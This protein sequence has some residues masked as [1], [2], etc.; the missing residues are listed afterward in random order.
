MP[1]LLFLVNEPNWFVSHRLAV[2]RAA[3][4][5]GFE[6]HVAGP[7]Q[8]PKEILEAGMTFHSV[9]LCRKGMNPFTELNAISS[10]VSLFRSVRPDI[11][12]LVTIKPYLYGGIA[13]RIVNIPAV[14]S[15]VAGLGTAFIRNDLLARIFRGLLYP[16]FKLAFGHGRQR[17]IFQNNDDRAVLEQ[18]GV[19][20]A[21]QS[22]VI[23]GSGADL[24]QYRPCAEIEGPPIIA[25]AARLLKDKGLVEFIDAARILKR[26]GIDARFWVIGER[27]PGNHATATEQEL[28]FWRT[29]GI[30]QFLGYRR[31][32]PDLF[33]Q[34]HI[35]CLPS[36]REGLPKVLVEG[37][38]A[39]RAVVTTNV[40]GCRDAIEPDRTGL[41]VPVRDTEKLADALQ[42]LIQNPDERR[43]MG[44]AGRDLAEREFEIGKIV[45][46]HLDIYHEL[47]QVRRAEKAEQ[48]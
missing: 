6:V 14:V 24:I 18:W 1:R 33:R 19:V 23:R 45:G 35:I 10:L 7:G 30:V 46:A 17:V 2:G 13:A 37:A 43:A 36:Y 48:T 47:L 8:V 31:D 41:L 39:G 4:D 11:A 44:R 3:Q 42:R 15:A 34:A 26:R 12:H 22:V 25:F 9:P 38:A 20:S 27:D 28:E 5:Q 16:M 21:H 40:P 29:E 32:V